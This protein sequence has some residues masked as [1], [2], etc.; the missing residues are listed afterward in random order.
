MP[1][2]T[3]MGIVVYGE[4]AELLALGRGFCRFFD[5]PKKQTPHISQGVPFE[6]FLTRGLFIIE[7]VA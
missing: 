5:T 3:D 6:S 1:V 2:S 4:I 7:F